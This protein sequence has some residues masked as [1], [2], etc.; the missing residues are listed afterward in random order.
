MDTGKIDGQLD[1]IQDLEIKRIKLMHKLMLYWQQ[2]NNQVH[3]LQLQNPVQVQD[4]LTT[5]WQTNVCQP[6]VAPFSSS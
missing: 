6:L 2:F 1:S 3:K 4:I 5:L